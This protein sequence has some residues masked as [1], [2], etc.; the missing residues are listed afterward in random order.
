ML[1]GHAGPVRSVEF[2]TDNR[3]IITASDDKTVKVIPSV[4]RCRVCYTRLMGFWVTVKQLWSLPSKRFRCS[5]IGHSNWVRTAAL[6]GD[7]RVAVSGGDDKQVK[8]W[9]IEHHQ[10]LH[11]FYE[12]EG[13]EMLCY[14]M[15]SIGCAIGFQIGRAHV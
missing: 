9:D 5:L 15:L 1:K 6:S 13:C 4:L 14:A 12:H 3:T 7:T 2:S 10:C 11:T 8:L